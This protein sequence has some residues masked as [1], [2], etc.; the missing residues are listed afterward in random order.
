MEE[1]EGHRCLAL[2]RGS[3]EAFYS[4]RLVGTAY[5]LLPSSPVPMQTFL[6]LRLET[7]LA[8]TS[9]THQGQLGPFMKR[10]GEH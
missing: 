7:H 9:S 1:M 3:G 8:S 5:I 10:S 6:P 4:L 2:A